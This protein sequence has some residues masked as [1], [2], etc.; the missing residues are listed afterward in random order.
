MRKAF[1]FSNLAFDG[2]WQIPSVYEIVW[3]LGPMRCLIK[4]IKLDLGARCPTIVYIFFDV[5]N[6]CLVGGTKV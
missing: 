4:E 3:F 6:G 5:L 2:S 1:G